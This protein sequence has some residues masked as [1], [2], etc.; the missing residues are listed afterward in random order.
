MKDLDDGLH[1]QGQTICSEYEDT[2]K[3]REMGNARI[4]GYYTVARR[5]QSLSGIS[6]R[7]VVL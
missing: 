2:D 1:T 7:K 3:N 4:I 6:R 5:E